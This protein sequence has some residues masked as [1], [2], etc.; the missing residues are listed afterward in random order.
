MK[1]KHNITIPSRVIKFIFTKIELRSYVLYSQPLQT[2]MSPT[3]NSAE[4]PART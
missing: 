4:L 3:V 2:N 1:K